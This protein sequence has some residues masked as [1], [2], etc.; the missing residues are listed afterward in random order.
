MN[1]RLKNDKAFKHTIDTAKTTFYDSYIAGD[2]CLEPAGLFLFYWNFGTTL[3]VL[4]S[5]FVVPAR[6]AFDS[7][8][9]TA[10]LVV[11]FITEVW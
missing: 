8:P 3:W 2:F 7:K 5:A 6:L 10:M 9:N 1:C 4:Y 11:D